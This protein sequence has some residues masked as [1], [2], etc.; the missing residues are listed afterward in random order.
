MYCSIVHPPI[1]ENNFEL[2]LSF[3]GMLQQNQFADLPLENL[4]LLISIFFDK[5]GIVKPNGVDR[6]TILLR[7]FTF[8]LRDR[9]RAWLRSLLANFITS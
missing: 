7:L 1:A 3:I 4:H 6:N 9:A 5:C 2:K 8:S